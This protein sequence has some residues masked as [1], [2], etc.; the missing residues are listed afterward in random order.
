MIVAQN[1]SYGCIQGDLNRFNIIITE[2]RP[3]F[4]DLEKLRLIVHLS[5]AGLYTLQKEVDEL[6][7]A[8]NDIEGWGKPWSETRSRQA[9]LLDFLRYVIPSALLF[10]V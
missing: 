7:G 10:F 9:M 1:H 2:N 6:H 3:R 5:G 4:I 8:L